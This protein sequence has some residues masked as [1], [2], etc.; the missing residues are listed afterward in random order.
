MI[1]PQWIQA[2]S[3]IL[4]A[5]AGRPAAPAYSSSTPTVNSW[6]DGSGWTVATGASKAAGGDRS[7]DTGTSLSPLLVVAGLIAFAV[8]A[9]RAKS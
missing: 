5:A 2:G 4:A 8:W 7:Q 3:Q 1:D 6:F 9:K